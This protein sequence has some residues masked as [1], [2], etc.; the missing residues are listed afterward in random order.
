MKP[1]T[2]SEAID[3]KEIEKRVLNLDL[4]SVYD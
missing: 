1:G 4:N 3:K 2:K